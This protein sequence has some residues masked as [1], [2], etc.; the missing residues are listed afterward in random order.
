MP[1]PTAAE[2]HFDQMLTDFSVGFME[3]TDERW[4]AD[5]VFPIINVAQQSG[6]YRVLP[7][8]Y[9]LQDQVHPRPMGGV[10][11]EIEYRMERQPYYVEEEGLR[12]K[13]DKNEAAN[14][15]G[16]G[17]PRQNKIRLLT[18]QH[19]IHRD[20]KWASMFM[21]AGVWGTDLTGVP[22]AP[23]AGQFQQWDQANVDVADE[24]ARR[25]DAIG[26]AT[27]M[28]PNVLIAGRAVLRGLKKNAAVKDAIKYTQT[29]VV[30][31]DILSGLFDLD[32]VLSPTGVY[33][34]AVG[35]MIDPVSGLP[36]PRETLAWIV[37]E[38][39]ALLVYSG[40]SAGLD[41]ISGGG[42]FAWTGLHGTGAFNTVVNRGTWDYG[43][44]FDVLQAWE[45][46][47]IA[48]DLGI[49][50]AAAVSATA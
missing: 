47:V 7:S 22:G 18:S 3:L 48:N 44:W 30:T 12:A 31:T 20:R 38:R 13:L 36:V 23:A 35:E 46:K 32:R 17:D 42:L 15:S 6:N 29:A 50:L 10:P 25:A 28:R 21:R 11:R 2:G 5:K 26:L 27:G 39:D 24:I 1:V 34:S 4:I 49:F 37:G 14:W 9:F 41:T 45:P 33:N 8:G 19:L 43:E 16:P 40:E